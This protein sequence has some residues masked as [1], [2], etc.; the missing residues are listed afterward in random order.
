MLI[1]TTLTFELLE[2]T[3]TKESILD[4]MI[5]D[6]NIMVR[7]TNEPST[8]LFHSSGTR[9]IGDNFYAF[10]FKRIIKMGFNSQVEFNAYK[11]KCY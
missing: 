11:Q 10:N 9:K 6:Y 3:S 1:E 4:F 2:K 7:P 8:F 5:T